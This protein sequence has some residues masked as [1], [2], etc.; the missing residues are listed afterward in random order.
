VDL[1]LFQLLLS[2]LRLPSVRQGLVG[3]VLF[4]LVLL[5]LVRLL[6]LLDQLDQQQYW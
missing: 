6:V 1:V 3:L 5:V 4:L 2:G